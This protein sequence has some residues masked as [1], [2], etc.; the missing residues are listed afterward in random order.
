MNF[1]SKSQALQDQFASRIAK[2]KTYIEIGAY[3]PV[4]KNNTY[5]LETILGWKG[6]SIEYDER[7]KQSWAERP[8]RKNSIFWESAL[9]FDYLAAVKKL[10]LSNRIGY[11]SCDI[12]PPKNTFAALQRVIEQGIIFDCITFEHDNYSRKENSLDYDIIAREYLKSKGYRVAVTEVYCKD[13]K[14]QF[15]TWFVYNDIDFQTMTFD[16]WRSSINA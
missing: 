12:E 2:N 4:S 8:E 9:D 13:P 3:K 11:L 5:N 15:E 6:F 7:H 14:N 10:K 1:K 16:Q